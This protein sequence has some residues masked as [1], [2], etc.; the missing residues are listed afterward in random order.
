MIKTLENRRIFRCSSWMI[1]IVLVCSLFTGCTLLDVKDKGGMINPDAASLEGE[2]S[3]DGDSAENDISRFM[4][5]KTGSESESEINGDRDTSE[6]EMQKTI[7]G[8]AW[9]TA[10]G[11][12]ALAEDR[13]Y[14]NQL[15]AAAG[16]YFVDYTADFMGT[17]RQEQVKSLFPYLENL[18]ADHRIECDGDEWYVIVPASEDWTITIN[19]M[20]GR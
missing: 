18:P 7:S 17:G 1:L 6:A 11:K 8:G 10:A 20:A 14:V 13:E 16:V 9:M 12:S 3:T 4:K 5:N 19:S 2:T 15:N